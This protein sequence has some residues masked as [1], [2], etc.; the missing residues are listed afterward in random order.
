MK[1]AVGTKR[2]FFKQVPMRKFDEIICTREIYILPTRRKHD[3]G[4]ACMELIAEKPNG[5][6]VK[7]G[8]YAD[9]AVFE[10]RWK[11]KIDCLYPSRIIHLFSCDYVFIDR[12]NGSD[13]LIHDEE[14][15]REWYGNKVVD[16]LKNDTEASRLR[17]E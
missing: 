1:I 5:E 4:Y 17:S 14:S 12:N 2:E 16:K 10:K 3:S 15:A 6:L 11:F 9:V 7:I 13:I 8:G